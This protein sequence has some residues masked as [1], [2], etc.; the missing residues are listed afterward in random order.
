[1]D[2]QVAPPDT[3]Q[4]IPPGRLWFGA[5]G[6]AVAWALQGFVCFLI[7]TQ[8]CGNGSGSWG[9]LSAVGVRVLIGA[10]SALFLAIAIASAMVSLANWK[11]LSEQGHIMEAEGR[12]RENFMALTGV[13]VGL[14]SA[15]GL[16]W[17]GIPPIFFEVCNTWR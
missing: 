5:T 4:H 14:S 15:V 1:M 17:A 11:M 3:I 16:V 13:F 9:P 2:T 6:A 12:A 7:A 10:V 8:A